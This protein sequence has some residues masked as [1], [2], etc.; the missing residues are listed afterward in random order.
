[1]VGVMMPPPTMSMMKEQIVHFIQTTL[2]NAVAKGILKNVPSFGLETPDRPEHGDFAT[3]LSLTLAKKEQKSPKAIAAL[4]IGEMTRHPHPLIQKIEMAGPGYINIFMTKA[5][6]HQALIDIHAQGASYGQTL[7]GAGKRVLIEFVSANPTGPL[8]VAHGR[9]AV[10]GE[11]I[12][13]LMTTVGYRVEREYYINDI[14]RQISL[15]GQSTAL[16]Y[17]ELFGKEITLPE[18]GYRGDYIIDMARVL[19]ES[20][21]DRH[22]VRS[23]EDPFFVEY[24]YKT[25]L[26][27]IRR[28]LDQ[29]GIVYDRW[30]AESTLV[31]DQE[32]VFDLL[33]SQGVLYEEAGA[34]WVATSRYGDDK[35]RVVKRAN[36]QTTYFASDIAYHQNKY[37]RGYDRMINIWGADHH[38]YVARV[39]A[40][41]AAM[42]YPPEKLHV[43][44]HQLVN[45]QRNGQPV[46]MSKRS[47]EFVTLREV[48]EE[49]GADVTR[50]FFLMRRADSSVD[51]DLEVAK[52][53]SDENPV[54]YVQYAYARICSIVRVAAAQGWNVSGQNILIEELL[55]LDQPE[56]QKLI[57]QLARYPEMILA[58]AE[59]LEPHR[60]TFY[61]QELAGGVH[62][63]Y[64]S[65]R[66]VSEDKALTHARLI[67][68]TA[69]QIVLKNAFHLIGIEAPERM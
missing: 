41:V 56:E 11:A 18:E 9:A 25:I 68:V 50:F 16:R 53:S 67:L 35:D 65:R 12:A 10:M 37:Q 24:S 5:S 38:G 20:E 1:M 22:L 33:R 60:M 63:Y 39:K 7:I 59:G 47:G 8:H 26:A 55:V 29:F 45:L 64:F 62:R 51:F 69:V 27:W 36:Q 13:R 49:V 14:G 61:L 40:A 43:L 46:A 19:K 57:K 58:A 31:P 21:G 4:L 15:L 34:L 28:D 66:V 52:K 6:W 48:M 32:T 17:Q 54:Y 23:P 30:F 42:G 44:I 2:E 3:T